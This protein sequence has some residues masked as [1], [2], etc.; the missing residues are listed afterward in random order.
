MHEVVQIGDEDPVEQELILRYLEEMQQEEYKSLSLEREGYSLVIMNPPFTAWKRIP[1]KERTALREFHGDVIKGDVGY[2]AYF[3]LAADNVIRP[4]E[5]LAAVTPKEFFAG[6]SAGSLRAR[7][8]LG[9]GGEKCAYI[10]MIVVKSAGE[11]AFSEGALYRDYL[12]VFRK[13]SKEEAGGSPMILAI[14]K[15]KLDEMDEREIEGVSRRIKSSMACDS[16]TIEDDLVLIRR[17]AY[18][19]SY[20]RR[21]SRNLKPLVAFYTGLGQRVLRRLTEDL[22]SLPKLSEVAELSYYRPGPKGAEE[23]TRGLFLA[24]YLGRGKTIFRIIGDSGDRLTAR[25]IAEV[26]KRKSGKRR[27]EGPTIVLSKSRLRPSLRSPAGVST[28]LLGDRA[29]WGDYR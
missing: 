1:E 4:D 18:P 5:R 24:R 29:E 11:V 7:M 27:K 25:I 2:W 8:L 14:L 20:I 28:L 13:V 23:Y 26:G 3:F 10:P 16:E 17:I 9:E 6:E 15:K 12:A 19:E 21:Y 22:L